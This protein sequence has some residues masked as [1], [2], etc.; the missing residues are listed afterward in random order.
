[1]LTKKD[2]Q[3]NEG[4]NS[5]SKP[6]ENESNSTKA[7]TAFPAQTKQFTPAKSFDTEYSYEAKKNPHQ[8]RVTIKYNVGFQNQLYIRGKGANLNW[9]KGIQLKN[10]KADEWIWE[11][12]A[13]FSH[14][15]FKV[16]LNDKQYETGDNH[17][18]T[19]GSSIVYSPHF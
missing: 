14:C 1:M 7:T 15:E 17:Y 3:K 2:P 11:T 10:V 19:Y 4:K 13:N 16:L 9:D 6:A 5:K 18:L 12:D 8:T